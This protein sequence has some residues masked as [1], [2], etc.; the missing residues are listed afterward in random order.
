MSYF[1]FAHSSTQTIY[2]LLCRYSFEGFILALTW[3]RENSENKIPVKNT[4]YTVLKMNRTI[5]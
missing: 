1:K 5:H 4:S 3:E 2:L